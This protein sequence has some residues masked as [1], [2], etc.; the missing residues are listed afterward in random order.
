[1]WFAILSTSGASGFGEIQKIN[2]EVRKIIL[3]KKI[4]LQTAR[5]CVCCPRETNKRISLGVSERHNFSIQTSTQLS[6]EILNDHVIKTL[7]NTPLSRANGIAI[8]Y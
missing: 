3:K 5:F 1:M 7:L 2:E 6:V 8:R 4:T